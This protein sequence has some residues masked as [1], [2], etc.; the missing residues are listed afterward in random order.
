MPVDEQDVERLPAVQPIAA[1]RSIAAWEGAAS[2]GMRAKA[3]RDAIIGDLLKEGIDN[4]YAV[5]PGTKKKTL[6]KPGAE[7]IG[8][9]LNL[10]PDYEIV[11]AIEDFDKPLFF[12]RYRCILRQRGTNVAVA[13]GI[14]SCNSREDRFAFRK[15]ARECP[16]CGAEAIIKGKEEY[17]GGWLCYKAKGGC[18]EKWED[19]SQQAGLFAATA[20]GK[21]RREAEEIFTDVNSIDKMGQKRSHVAATLDLG[22]SEVFTQDMEDRNGDDDT[23]KAAPPKRE[24]PKPAPPKVQEPEPE[25][26]ASVKATEPPVTTGPGEEMVKGIVQA[27]AETKS[28]PD[29]EKQWTRFGVRLKGLDQWFN[30]FDLT[31]GATARR[32]KENGFEVELYYKREEYRGKPQ[33]NIVDILPVGLPEA[34]DDNVPF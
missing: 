31:C 6:L 9:A 21:V 15:A 12:Y 14:G 20:T 27:I 1:N 3:E 8:D 11:T 5:I 26:P 10:W 19:A 25:I 2:R 22:F 16:T 32:A 18:G 7:K 4:D 34:P 13:S 29:A 23:V 28:R 30:T 33:F 17:G 24:N